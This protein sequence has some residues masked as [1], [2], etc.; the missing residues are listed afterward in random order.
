MS[1]PFG[2]ARGFGGMS[3]LVAKLTL[4]LMPEDFVLTTDQVELPAAG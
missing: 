1:L 4:G 2:P 3:E